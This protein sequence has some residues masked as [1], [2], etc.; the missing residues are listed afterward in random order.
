MS[1]N[2]II[3]V[4]CIQTMLPLFDTIAGIFTV[5]YYFDY[6]ANHYDHPCIIYLIIY[7]FSR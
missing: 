5:H 2:H 6:Y 1:Y 7:G 3:V 4:L